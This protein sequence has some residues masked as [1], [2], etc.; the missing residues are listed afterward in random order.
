MW[1][2][3]A[4]C[5]FGFRGLPGQLKLHAETAKCS[6]AGRLPAAEN[7][8]RGAGRF[9]YGRFKIESWRGYEP[10]EVQI[11]GNECHQRHLRALQTGVKH[12]S[13][14]FKGR[15]TDTTKTAASTL[16]IVEHF[17][18][19]KNISTCQIAR[20]VQKRVK[21]NNLIMTTTQN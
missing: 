4:F 14:R 5:Y 10:G 20:F 11:C 21:S 7:S 3:W 6:S 9:K 16:F 13:S 2:P 19:V 18:V 17:D 15:W 12:S 8:I 1:L